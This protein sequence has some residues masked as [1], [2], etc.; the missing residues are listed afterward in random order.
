[1]REKYLGMVVAILILC[2]GTTSIAQ[3]IVKD[4]EDGSPVAY[5]HVFNQNVEYIGQTDAEGKLPDDL[6]GATAISISHVAYQPEK[7]DVGKLGKEI[8][9]TPATFNIGEAVVSIPK[10][11]CIR[12]SCF[13]RDYGIADGRISKRKQLEEPIGS[14]SEGVGCAYIL[15]DGSK[16][17]KWYYHTE[18]ELV[19]ETL[20]GGENS[21]I[22]YLKPKSVVER[23]KSSKNMTLRD[24]GSYQQILEKGHVV[25]NVVTDSADHIIRVDYDE[26]YPDTVKSYNLLLAKVKIYELKNNCTYRLDNDDYVSQADLIRCKSFGHINIKVMGSIID[27]NAVSEL[28]VIKAEYLSK[29]DYKKAMTEEKARSKSKRASMSANELDNYITA[30]QIPAITEEMRHTIEVTKEWEKNNSKKKKK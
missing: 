21:T 6:Q 26:L 10:P 20:R 23:A 25:G 5:A 15:L 12:L 17:A 13:K 30:H 22:H 8:L 27:F 1:M 14:L 11:Y 3:T 29:E 7:R 2:C 28:F 9:M 4:K 18:R 19:K 16:D 24:K